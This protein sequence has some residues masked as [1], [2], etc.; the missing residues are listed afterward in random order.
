[1]VPRWFGSEGAAA[2]KNNEIQRWDL[3]VMA[4]EARQK[5][6]RTAHED[7]MISFFTPASPLKRM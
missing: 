4:F 7:T 2:A 5:V 3:P 6:E 1:M